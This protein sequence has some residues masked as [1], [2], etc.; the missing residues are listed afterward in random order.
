[1]LIYR[2]YNEWK[3]QRYHVMKGQKSHKRNDKGQAL[4]SQDQVELNEDWDLDPLDPLEQWAR[5][6]ANE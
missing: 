4:F 6:L 5:D 3:A 2:T 1:M